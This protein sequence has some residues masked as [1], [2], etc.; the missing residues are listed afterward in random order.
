MIL[1]SSPKV[2]T[3]F[4]HLYTLNAS[5]NRHCKDV[6]DIIS[7]L[8]CVLRME[9]INSIYLIYILFIHYIK[10]NNIN[11]YDIDNIYNYLSKI[12]IFIDFNYKNSITTENIY[13]DDET[14]LLSS[15]I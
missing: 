8:S 3:K 15:V 10:Y 2:I 5:K 13:V 6:I 11:N 7:D 9:N 1:L 12:K 14:G 4:L